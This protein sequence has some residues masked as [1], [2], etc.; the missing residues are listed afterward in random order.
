MKFT[1]TMQFLQEKEFKND[2]DNMS[3]HKKS[4]KCI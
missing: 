1:T 3:Q 2:D 4:L